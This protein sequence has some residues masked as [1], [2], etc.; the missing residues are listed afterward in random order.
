MS[1]ANIQKLTVA[2]EVFPVSENE[3][4]TNIASSPTAASQES[5]HASPAPECGDSGIFD[6]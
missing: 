4:E 6:I 3:G 1:V 2:P 5:Y